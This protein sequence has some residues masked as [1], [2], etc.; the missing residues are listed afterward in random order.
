MRYPTLNFTRETAIGIDG[1]LKVLNKEA[2]PGASGSGMF[3]L[4]SND[5]GQ[6]QMVLSGIFIGHRKDASGNIGLQ[7]AAILQHLKATNL[8]A[9]NELKKAIQNNSCN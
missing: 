6:A 2:L 1:T 3:V 8:D 7:T 5:Q 4:D 9:Y